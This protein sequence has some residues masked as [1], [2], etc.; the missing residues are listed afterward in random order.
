MVLNHL[1]A[2]FFFSGPLLYIGLLILAI[3]SAV[4]TIDPGIRKALRYAGFGLTAG[5]LLFGLIV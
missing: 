5:A 4:A 3:P 2:V 1:A